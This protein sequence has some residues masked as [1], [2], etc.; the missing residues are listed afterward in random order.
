MEATRID[1]RRLGRRHSL[2]YFLLAF[3]LVSAAT[4]PHFARAQAW[5]AK[6]VRVIVSISPGSATD[7][8]ARMFSESAAKSLG[9]QFVVE[10]IVGASGMIGAQAAARAAP[11]G[12]T[13]YVAPSSSLASNPYMFK[14]LPYD[15]FKDFAAIGLITDSS[16]LMISVN[17]DLP[18]NTLRDLLNMAKAQPG[19]LS[20]ALDASSGFQIVIGRLLKYRGA[21]DMVEVPYKSGPQG[22]QDTV[23]GRTQVLLSSPAAAQGLTKAGKLR[24]LAL[25]SEKRFPGMEQVPTVWETFPGFKVDGWFALVGPA[26]MPQEIIRRASRELGDFAAKPD[27]KQKL[28]QLGLTLSRHRS[29][30][31]TAKFISD[32]QAYWAK[33]TKEVNF[34]PE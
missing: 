20:Y 24:I 19:K 23:A 2:Q 8:S 17:P 32:E 33:V 9:Q 34:V 11:D 15:P 10:N 22:M 26:G 25:T 13:L 16:P 30:E 27:A 28:L 12:Y 14:S 18:V 21:I 1:K 3:A 6:P 29:P 5:P 4:A 31:E 7:S